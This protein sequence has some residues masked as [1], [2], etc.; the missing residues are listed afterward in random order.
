MY[1][2]LPQARKEV[3]K[4]HVGRKATNELCFCNHVNY[5]S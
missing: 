5:E 4:L 2:H 3:R 1:M